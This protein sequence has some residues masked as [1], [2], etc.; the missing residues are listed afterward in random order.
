MTGRA[1]A[2]ENTNTAARSTREAARLLGVKPGTLG[3]AVWAGR[4]PEPARSPAGDFLWSIEGIRR[5]SRILLG[6]PYAEPKEG[7]P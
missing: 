5:A 2:A 4:V 1:P 6:R 7:A 3:A